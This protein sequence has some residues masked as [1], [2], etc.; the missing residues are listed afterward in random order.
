LLLARLPH[1]FCAA[2]LLS[3]FAIFA[4][5][6]NRSVALNNEWDTR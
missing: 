1:L 6:H 4:R 5:R 2:G 3:L